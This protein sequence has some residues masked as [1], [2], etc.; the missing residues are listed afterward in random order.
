MCLDIFHRPA[1]PAMPNTH[2]CTLL[3]V[4]LVAQLNV[5]FA[6]TFVQLCIT[7]THM[8]MVPCVCAHIVCVCVSVFEASQADLSSGSWPWLY[9]PAWPGLAGV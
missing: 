9:D 6:F 1:V 5:S 8:H 7:H 2:E 4:W 3:C